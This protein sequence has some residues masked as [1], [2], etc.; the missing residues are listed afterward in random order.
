MAQ[1]KVVA[2]KTGYYDNKRYREGQMFFMDDAS[3]IRDKDGHIISPSWI[4]IVDKTD[5]NKKPRN[6]ADIRYSEDVI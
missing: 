2:T 6:K 3:F 4:E 1:I 5:S